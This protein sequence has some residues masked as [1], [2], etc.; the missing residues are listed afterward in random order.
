MSN[1]LRN[2]VSVVMIGAAFGY[3]FAPQIHRVKH[4]FL[5]WKARRARRRRGGLLR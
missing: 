1:Y 3:I 2:L 5:A 4:V